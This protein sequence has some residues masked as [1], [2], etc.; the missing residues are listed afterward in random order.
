[1]CPLLI[2]LTRTYCR[3]IEY[4]ELKENHKQQ[5]AQIL[6]PQ[7]TTWISSFVSESVVRMFFELGQFGA[8]TTALGN[9]FLCL[10]NFLLKNLFIISKMRYDQSPCRAFYIGGEE[11]E[12]YNEQ[13]FI[14][15]TQARSLSFGMI[16]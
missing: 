10:T 13:F 11:S 14:I 2:N 16:L 4:L 3:F 8:A 9:L 7:R 12:I 5:W 6:V 1:M 15:R